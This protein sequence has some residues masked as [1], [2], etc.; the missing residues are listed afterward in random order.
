MQIKYLT[1]SSSRPPSVLRKAGAMVATVALAG[2]ALMFSAVLLTL[3]LSI[4]A[5]AFAYLWWKTRGVRKQMQAQMRDFSPPGANVERE[6]FR[7]E[8]YTGEVI[9]GE[10]VRVDEPR[11]RIAR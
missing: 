4:G 3:V 9:E 5:M 10:A 8:A 2:V 11:D 6:V 7:G 1:N